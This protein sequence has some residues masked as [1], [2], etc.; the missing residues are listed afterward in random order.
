MN[1]INTAFEKKILTEAECDEFI[2]NVTSKG[3]ILPF[4]TLKKYKE[5]LS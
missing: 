5:S 4:K 3:S 1:F 2:Y